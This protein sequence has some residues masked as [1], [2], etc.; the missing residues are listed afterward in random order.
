MRLMRSLGSGSCADAKFA[1]SPKETKAKMT[2]HMGF[3]DLLQNMSALLY[4]EMLFFDVG[5]AHATD[6]I[7]RLASD[8]TELRRLNIVR[9]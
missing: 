6:A 7:V 2:R 8:T 5:P 3:D 9:K 1:T 4:L